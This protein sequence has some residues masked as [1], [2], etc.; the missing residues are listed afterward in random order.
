MA[1][2]WSAIRALIETVSFLSVIVAIPF[3]F[4]Q[5][6]NEKKDRA[7]DSAMQFIILANDKYADVLSRLSAPWEQLSIPELLQNNPTPQGIAQAKM[8]ATQGVKDTDI[9][10]AA[11][12]YKAVLIC[13]EA[14]HCD[15]K[16]IDDFF[17]TD[18]QGFYC[19]Y[20]ERLKLIAHRLNRPNYVD[21]LKNYAGACS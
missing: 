13:R 6:N 3:F 17:R 2:K 5:Q 16:L 18:I 15:P 8:A 14:E 11:Q 9:E 19:S 20:D 4:I 7:A 12:F 1:G 10:Q 21:D